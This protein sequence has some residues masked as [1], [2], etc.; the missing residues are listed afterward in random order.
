MTGFVMSL[1]ERIF[2]EEEASIMLLLKVSVSA[3]VVLVLVLMGF[4]FRSRR[5][6]FQLKREIFT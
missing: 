3:E 2:D 4:I 1:L 5:E 6:I